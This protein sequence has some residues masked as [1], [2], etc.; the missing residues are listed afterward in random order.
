[1]NIR[2][3]VIAAIIGAS[4]LSAAPAEAA[5]CIKGA[6]IGGIA[7]HLTHHSTVLGALGGCIV[8]KIVA[9]YTGSLTFDD[10]TGKMLGDDRDL[11]HVANDTNISIVKVSSL[12]GFKRGD[13]PVATTAAV[14]RLDNEIAANASLTATLQEAGYKPTDVL[15]VSAKG[16]GVL[17]IN[18]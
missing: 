14:T 17:F 12:N 6:I 1:M 13:V 11:G 16:G 18:A 10:V 7:A 9:H 3:T 4:L 5:G 8:G 2:A 15:A